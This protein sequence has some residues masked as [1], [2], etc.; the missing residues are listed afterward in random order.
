MKKEDFT[1]ITLTKFL[2]E[3]E[4][5]NIGKGQT[6]LMAK[7]QMKKG[8]DYLHIEG[9]KFYRIPL[10]SI[11]NYFHN[12]EKEDE[13]EVELPVVVEPKEAKSPD[14]LKK[15]E[16]VAPTVPTSRPPRVEKPRIIR[17]RSRKK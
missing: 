16:I 5:T 3:G 12:L 4:F 7:A 8:E 9:T 11:Q 14:V 13:A 2:E 17:R 15:E 1:E 6:V 10:A